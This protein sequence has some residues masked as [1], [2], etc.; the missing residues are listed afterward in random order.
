MNG[1]ALSFRCEVSVRSTQDYP[2][3][4]CVFPGDHELGMK[5]VK[6][7]KSNPIDKVASAYD[8]WSRTY[9]SVENPTRVLAASAVR[10]QSLN[11]HHR[12]VL[13]IGCG[14]GL[15]TR[16]LAEHCRS[17]TALDFSAGMLAQARSNVSASNVRFVQDDIRLQWSVDDSSIDLIICTLVLEHIED[18]RHIFSEA[19]RVLSLLTAALCWLT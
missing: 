12:D 5:E 18:L 14:T 8:D 4:A 7:L 10:Q 16:Y 9:E 3:Q 19:A 17:V 15:N 2:A 13:E 6:M 1:C 11:L